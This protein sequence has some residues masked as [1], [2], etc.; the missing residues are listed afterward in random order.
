M[1]SIG[2][3]G[4]LDLNIL[5]DSLGLSSSRFPRGLGGTVL[6]HILIE[7]AKRGQKIIVFTLDLTVNAPLIIEKDLVKIYVCPSRINHK[8]RDIFALE[9][10]YLLD[11]MQKEKPDIINAHWSYEFA[12]AA[13]SS[14]IPTLVSAHDI[15]LQILR[16][17]FSPYQFMRTLMAFEVLR[18]IDGMTVESEYV[19]FHLSK[20]VS[21]KGKI[22]V[23]P[24]GLSIDVFSIFKEKKEKANKTIIFAA[25]L[26]GWG[27]RKNTK[28]LIQAFSIVHKEIRSSELWLFGIGHGNNEPAMLWAQKNNVADGIHFWGETDNQTMLRLWVDNVDVIVHP[29]LEES[30]CMTIIEGMAVGIPVIGGVK[31]GA[32]PETLGF[33]K[34]GILVDVSSPP[35]LAEIMLELASDTNKR[36]Q[37]SNSGRAYA[38]ANYRIEHVV[39][40]YEAQYQN[41]SNPIVYE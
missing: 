19:Q 31:S 8:A 40:L 6:P 24:N 10:R 25:A 16:Y 41:L 23:I 28:K 4:P 22:S 36:Q 33:G 39:D 21:S 15:P 11:C 35:L 1:Y 38:L 18:K 13:L 20:Y 14:G 2:I 37:Y 26:N 30:F 3:A 9:R 5:C 29:A 7:L 12:L 32:V 27:R 17:N 34:G